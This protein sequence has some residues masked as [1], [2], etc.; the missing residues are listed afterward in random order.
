MPGS[1]SD[2]EMHLRLDNV[3]DQRVDDQ[4]GLPGSGRVMSGGV[5]LMI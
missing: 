4:V 1:T 5:S 3:F 2:I